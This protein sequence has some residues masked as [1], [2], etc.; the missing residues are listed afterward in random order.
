M[1]RESWIASRRL[2][3]A[4]AGLALA[5]LVTPAVA[6]HLSLEASSSLMGCGVAT[7]IG[8][9]NIA[10]LY[11]DGDPC[12]S[13]EFGIT[14]NVAFTNIK[15]CAPG[16]K[17]NCQVID[18]VIV[19]TGSTRLRIASSVFNSNP[20]LLHAMPYVPTSPGQ[21][22]TNC[23]TF[24]TGLTYGPV[25]TADVYIADK[26]VQNIPLQVYG[27][28][29]PQCGSPQSPPGNGLLGVALVG[30]A[31]GYFSCNTDGKT[32][33][34]PDVSPSIVIPNPVSK[35]QNDNNGVTIALSQIPPSGS[36]KPVLGLLI[37]GVGTQADNTPPEGT[38]PLLA[39]PIFGGI[40]LS[41]NGNNSP[42][43][44]DS[45]TSTL[46]VNLSLPNCSFT[47]PGYCPSTPQCTFA[48]YCP[49]SDIDISLLLSGFNA[50][51]IEVGYTITD[52]DPLTEAGDI[53]SL[54]SSER[55]CTSYFRV[56]PARWARLQSTRCRRRVK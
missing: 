25:Q 9:A 1:K 49:S 50:T 23:A 17:T 13:T 54:F 53:A 5:W 7:N 11:V 42:A 46:L 10:P 40:N 35:F 34:Q 32:G 6:Q 24:G 14:A 52:A 51:T 29:L 43:L 8:H 12:N 16:N 28:N 20:S 38:I 47:F 48:G 36:T 15:I 18:H 37:F 21:I 26:F 31:G 27:Q 19:D 56:N 41:L 3:A 30:G 33:C 55:R 4:A 39:D 44:I 45:G 2:L 22:L